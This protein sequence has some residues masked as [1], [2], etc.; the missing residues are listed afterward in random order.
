MYIKRFLNTASFPFNNAVV[1]V[2][3]CALVW[4]QVEGEMI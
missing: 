2:I 1:E 4:I 3:N